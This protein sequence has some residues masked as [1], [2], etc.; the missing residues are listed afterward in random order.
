MKSAQPYKCLYFLGIGGIGMSALAKY[1]A[2]RGVIVSGYDRTET[3]ITKSL[4]S[5]GIDVHYSPDISLIPDDIE[6]VIYTPAIQSDHPEFQ[7]F[8]EAK[9]PM[10]KRSQAVAELVNEH[11]CIA[12]AGTHGKTTITSLIAHI[13][14]SSGKDVLAFVGGMMKNYNSNL[15][16]SAQ[17]EYCVVEADEYDRSFLKLRPDIA[18]ISAVDADHLDIYGNFEELK[19]AFSAFAGFIKPQGKLI[20]HQDVV[21]KTENVNTVRYGINNHDGI[22]ARN[23]H[24][25][26]GKYLFDIYNSNVCLAADVAFPFPGI[27]NIENALAATSAAL[28]AGLEISEI[29]KALS[30]FNGIHRRFDIRIQREDIVYIDDYAHHPKEIDALIRGVRD[31]YPDSEIT[32]IFQPHLYSR[33]RD[34]A[35]EFARSL[36]QLDHIIL[37]EIY[38][39][40]EMPIPG[41][42]S[43][44]LFDMINHPNKVIC[45][46]TRIPDLLQTMKLQV[47]LTIGAGDI[48]TLVD[49]IEKIFL[50]SGEEGR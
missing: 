12:V 40:R 8:I 33:T 5:M 18:V 32:G 4:V 9:V 23:I 41:I 10:I 6:C 7:F 50:Q 34:F 28:S 14:K 24:Y 17:P 49:P 31:M 27:H 44:Y 20:I 21:F 43:Q 39:A 48:D 16:Y 36:E 15:I 19:E 37:T 13:F 1:Y 35:Q 29:V 38:P 47:L 11:F 26:N 3:E 25:G 45:N 42:S 46:K 22:N 30:G 2:Q